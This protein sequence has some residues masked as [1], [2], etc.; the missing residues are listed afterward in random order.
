MQTL[1]AQLS[2]IPRRAPSASRAS[3]A[4]PKRSAV[5]QTGRGAS[6]KVGS[7]VMTTKRR[8]ALASR[9][10]SDSPN[11]EGHPGPQS[12]RLRARNSPDTVGRIDVRVRPRLLAEQP[13]GRNPDGAV[14]TTKRR[15]AIAA[16]QDLRHSARRRGASADHLRT[17]D[18]LDGRQRVPDP[19]SLADRHPDSSGHPAREAGRVRRGDY[20]DTVCPIERGVRAGIFQAQPGLDDPVRRAFPRRADC[21]YT[22]ATIGVE[23]LQGAPPARQTPRSATSTRRCAGSNAGA[24]APCAGRSTACSTSAPRSPRSPPS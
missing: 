2:W 21:R 19:A 15:S 20:A 17:P 22:V 14:M 5:R 1:S 11:S 18:R 13:G 4:K 9:R 23:P 6:P 16:R 12:R 7:A 10:T 8:A 3:R 24:S